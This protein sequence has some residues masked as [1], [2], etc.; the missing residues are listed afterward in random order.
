MV[1]VVRPP[2]KEQ[3]FDQISAAVSEVLRRAGLLSEMTLE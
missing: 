1:F 2:L 3:L